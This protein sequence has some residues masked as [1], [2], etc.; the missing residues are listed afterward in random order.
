V[1]INPRAADAAYQEA[2]RLGFYNDLST[3]Q[4]R[5]WINLL[6]P[7]LPLHVAIDEV[8]PTAARWG[9]VPRSYIR[10]LQDNAFPLAL[11]NR[12]IAEADAF[13][14][15]NKFQVLTLDSSH[16][17]FA[18]RPDELAAQLDALA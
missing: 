3:A 4:A 14:P 8:H 1:R 5:P 16:S 18:S 7:D 12:Q 15:A 6:T 13:T 11:Q 10:T 9:R 17:S 2:L